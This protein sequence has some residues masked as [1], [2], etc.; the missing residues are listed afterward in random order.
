MFICD[1]S[2]PNNGITV[3]DIYIILPLKSASIIIK[4]ESKAYPLDNYVFK[5]LINKLNQNVKEGSPQ[6]LSK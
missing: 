3:S 6:A 2:K 4:N 5:Y 1:E